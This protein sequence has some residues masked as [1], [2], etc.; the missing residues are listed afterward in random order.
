[1]GIEKT[2]YEDINGADVSVRRDAHNRTIY[3]SSRFK[4]LPFSVQE[5]INRAVENEQLKAAKRNIKNL[6]F[7]KDIDAKSANLIPIILNNYKTN[8][9]L[10]AQVMDS[11]GNSAYTVNTYG[12]PALRSFVTPNV[13]ISPTEASAIFSQKGIP[14]LIIRKK[15]QSVLLNG[16][17]IKNSRLTPKQMDIVNE[18]SGRLGFP[19]HVSNGIRDSL[20]Y[21]GAL[22]F[23]VFSFDNPMTLGQPVELLVKMG[24]LRK[25]CVSY[26][27]TLDRWNTMHLP[28]TNPTSEDFLLPKKYFIPF[29]G[30][31]VDRSRTCR[32]V[33]APQAG[34]WGNIITMG[35]GISDIP[36]WYEAVRNYT[37]VIE[38]IPT[39]IMQMSI[40]ARQINVDG[41]LMT[42]GNAIMSQ[43][44]QENTIKVRELSP[45]N[46][47][48]LDVLG[49]LTAIQRDF[50]EVPSLVRLL[51]QDVGGKATLPEEMLWSS[52]RGAFSSGDQTEGAQEKQWEGVK[53]IHKDVEHQVK[54]AAMIIIIDA[55]GVGRDVIKA[56]P[57]TSVEFDNPIVANAEVRAEIAGDLSKSLFDLVAGGVPVDAAF[58]FI[59]AYGDHEF[60]VR[61]DLIED[62]KRRQKEADEYERKKREKEL[63]LMDAQIEGAALQAAAKA[64]GDG[65]YDRM[66]QRKHEK[67]RL[68]GKRDEGLS[69]ARNKKL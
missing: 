12:D 17:K 15:S 7:I 45:N 25:G 4:A 9:P 38:A 35:W 59:A 60:N 68:A 69:K 20:V 58:E 48:N 62:L 18:N 34:Y 30:S 21:G 32:I 10:T 49:Q 64:G 31:D 36:G 54:N 8:T 43:L 24:L 42:E 50:S 41:A 56:L 6:R 51:R 16:V 52:E 33:T 65:G 37:N 29:L 14:E 3:R 63:E 57:Y 47:V 66:E 22:M 39:M 13:W 1:M 27:V 26:F 5:R 11:I 61:S 40:L 23:P 55:L 46:P 19:Y 53:Y 28:N 2:V 67:T 44:A